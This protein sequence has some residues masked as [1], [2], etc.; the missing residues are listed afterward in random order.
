MTLRD[1]VKTSEFWITVLTVVVF[2]LLDAFL[3][4]HL[5]RPELIAGGGAY[6]V[7]RSVAKGLSK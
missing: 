7:G 1:G 4:T 3:G 2:P 6:A 5:S